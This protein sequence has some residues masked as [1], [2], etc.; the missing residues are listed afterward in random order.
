MELGLPRSRQQPRPQH[1]PRARRGGPAC[2]RPRP[3]GSKL[4]ILLQATRSL[5]LTCD[6]LCI[7]PTPLPSR[8]ARPDARAS[9]SGSPAPSCHPRGRRL[10]QVPPSSSDR[11]RPC[12]GQAKRLRPVPCAR[13]TGRAGR[14][15]GWQ[16]RLRHVASLAHHGHA[17]W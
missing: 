8:P 2:P 17:F 4:Q 9:S 16:R 3:G 5:L 1:A 10:G 11:P 6:R 12:P 14:G 7:V 13:P 15:Q